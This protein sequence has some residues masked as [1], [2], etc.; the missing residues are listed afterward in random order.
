MRA[1]GGPYYAPVAYG[2]FKIDWILWGARPFPWAVT[3]LLLHIANTWLL[4]FLALRLWRSH[5]AAWWASFG[6]AILFPANALAVMWIATRA[7]LIAAFFYL[8]AMIAALWFARAD[9]FERRAAAAVV[10]FAALS[11]FAKESG[12][13]VLGAIAIVIF[14]ERRRQGRRLIFP[15]L[16]PLFTALFAVLLLYFGLRTNSGAIPINFSGGPISYTS[17]PRVLWENLLT[18]G[19]RTH[20]LLALVAVAVAASLRLRGLRPSLGSLTKDEV[21]LAVMLFAVAIAPFVLLPE[22]P[23]QYSYLPGISAALLLGAIANSLYENVPEGQSSFA[24]I[25]LAPII[26]VV[27]LYVTLTVQ[28]SLKWMQLAEINTLVLNQI[29]AQQ[30]RVKPNTFIILSYAEIDYRNRFPEGFNVWGFPFALRVLY[31]D[32]TVDGEINREGEPLTGDKLSTVH[33]T[34]RGGDAPTVLKTGAS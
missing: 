8:A 16:I 23:E 25:A 1:S 21:T 28:Y 20:G 26:F 12:I 15:A 31:M 2:S 14:Y 7:H 19:W 32:R 29:V 6:F 24:P 4:Y 5:A 22:Q 13:T 10:I 9:R 17:S 34:Y 3:N 18:H 33:F 27:V 30:P 11:V